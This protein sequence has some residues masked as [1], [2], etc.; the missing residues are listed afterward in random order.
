MYQKWPKLLF[1]N[2]KPAKKGTTPVHQQAVSHAMVL[3]TYDPDQD[4]F[5]FKNTYDDESGGQPKKFKIERTHPN[6]PEELYFVHIDIRDMDN[7]PSQ[8]QRKANKEAEMRTKKQRYSTQRRRCSSGTPSLT[9]GDRE[10]SKSGPFLG[11]E[12]TT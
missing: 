9:H 4:S 2:K 10:S 8:K 12:Y 5:I 11:F 7:L 3:D 1:Q 6:A